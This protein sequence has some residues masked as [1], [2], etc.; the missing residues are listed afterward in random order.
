MLGPKLKL[1]F[2]ELSLREELK[3]KQRSQV[4]WLKAG[5]ANTK[6]F[7]L[8]ANARRSKNFISRLVD[9]NSVF[10]D[11]SDIARS[12]LSFFSIQLGSAACCPQRLNFQRIF[13]D[14][15]F[16]CNCL[17]TPFSVQE[18]RSAIF[19]CAP[20]KAPGPDGLS[21]LFFQRFW[22]LIKEDV[23]EA[24]SLFFRG[25]STYAPSTGA[26]CALSPKKRGPTR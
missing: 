26:G 15:P 16:D 19:S 18:V 14:G 21:I 2:E 1:R 7:H 3:W 9:G 4:H 13:V 10:T 25:C 23:L 5:D 12:L 22:E 24:F 17:Q 8:H 20:E 11:H 6:F